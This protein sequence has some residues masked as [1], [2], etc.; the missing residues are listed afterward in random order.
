MPSF[1]DKSSVL[2]LKLV[3]IH[4]LKASIIIFF[5]VVMLRRQVCPDP[6]LILIWQR[7]IGCLEYGNVAFF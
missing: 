1:G 6:F 7:V 4:L 3:E 5:S 2:L